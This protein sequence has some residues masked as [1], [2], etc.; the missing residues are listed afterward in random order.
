M[1]NYLSAELYKLV[2][3]R[4]Y[5]VLSAVFLGL[6]LLLL[7]TTG[8]VSY[9]YSGNA[10]LRESMDVMP[11]FLLGGILLA[12]VVAAGTFDDQYGRD[13]MKNE[14]AFGVPRRRI[15]L[16]KLL[17]G[18]VAGVVLAAVATALYVLLCALFIG[19]RGSGDLLVS[20][21][22]AT[23]TFLCAVP[24]WLASLSVT[25][26]LLFWTRSAAAS[27]TASLLSMLLLVPLCI[28]APGPG[29]PAP[30]LLWLFQNIY[31]AAPFWDEPNN[32]LHCWLV[33]I[34]W[35]AVAT[36]VGVAVFRK[37]EL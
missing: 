9:S 5:M 24:L 10:S 31:F 17:S 19:V 18:A 2:H 3:R 12:P 21:T 30:K 34:G 22:A 11:M 28:A 6:E 1:L 37:K 4:S 14:V 20:L 23:V 8:V 36:V 16:G 25:M 27:V 32:L 26:L 7:L 29:F 33:G 13:T 35:L 15:Y